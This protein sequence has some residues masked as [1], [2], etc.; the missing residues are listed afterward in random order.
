MKELIQASKK[1]SHAL[2]HEPEKYG[3]V[4]EDNGWTDLATFAEKLS[5]P[6][7]TIVEITKQDSKQRYAIEEGRIRAVQGHSTKVN[8]QFTSA[9][10]PKHLWHGTNE[11]AYPEIM[12]MGLLPMGRHHVHLSESVEQARI[13]G[14]RRKGGLVLLQ[15]D[16]LTL[17][18]EVPLYKSPNGVWLADRV[19]AKY[20]TRR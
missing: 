14:E 10:P 17:S 5:L 12:K 8:L 3:I 20:I 6:V 18:E 1:M 9:V 13:V 19:P 11:N 7:E 16:A 15:I 2:R 4:L